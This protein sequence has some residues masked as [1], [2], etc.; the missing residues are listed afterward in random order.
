MVEGRSRDALDHAAG[1]FQQR[2]A[3]ADTIRST[4]SA[5]VLRSGAEL[6]TG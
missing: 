3:R 6:S 2:A 4:A 1:V 5:H